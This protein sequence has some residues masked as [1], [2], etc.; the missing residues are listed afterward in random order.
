MPWI[1]VQVERF[2]MTMVYPSGTTVVVRALTDRQFVFEVTFG[3]DTHEESEIMLAAA[4][5]LGIRFEYESVLQTGSDEG[6]FERRM[7]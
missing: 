7:A 5:E 2:H 3:P 4:D 1:H 6:A